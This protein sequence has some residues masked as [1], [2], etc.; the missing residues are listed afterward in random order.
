MSL[1]YNPQRPSVTFVMPNFNHARFLRF[2]VTALLK[3]T[4][5]AEKLLIFDD[6]STDNSLD[7]LHEF[8]GAHPCIE[9]IAR[10]KNIGVVAN[11]ND[12]LARCETDLIA[13][14]AADDLVFPGFLQQSVSVLARYPHAAFV[15]AC[16]QIRDDKDNIT[17]ERPFIYPLFRQ[18]YVS[19]EDYR[20]FLRH[21]DNHFLGAVAVFRASALREIGGF[22]ETLGPLSDGI[23]M[24]QLAA[25]HGFCFIPSQL[26]VWRNFGTNYSSTHSKEPARLE[27]LIEK[28]QIIIQNEPDGLFDKGYANRLA[29]RMRFNGARL[30]IMQED[31]SDPSVQQKLKQWELPSSLLHLTAMTGRAGRWALL[32]FIYLRFKPFSAYLFLRQKF[33]RLCAN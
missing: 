8:A 32:L 16:V 11:L 12:G 5:P 4:S 23:V 7:I 27:S 17:G 21:S 29:Q 22:N 9:L 13:F 10:E 24:R 30:L 1:D 25:R 3:Q 18:G 6:A 20:R 33:V 31:L 26:G 15:S 19:A 28:M 2:S 14:S